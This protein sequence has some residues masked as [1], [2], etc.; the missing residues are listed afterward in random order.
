M[1]TKE[2][3]KEYKYLCFALRLKCELEEKSG[4]NTDET[5]HSNTVRLDQLLGDDVKSPLRFDSMKTKLLFITKSSQGFFH[6]LF[7]LFACSK[8]FMRN[9]KEIYFRFEHDY[10][11]V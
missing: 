8:R 5:V 1:S 9:F 4:W 6:V 10:P 3:V 11:T 7:V 2:T